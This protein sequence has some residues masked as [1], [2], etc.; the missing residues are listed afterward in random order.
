MAWSIENPAHVDT[1]FT[2]FRLRQT[3]VPFPDADAIKMSELLFF[4]PTASADQ[5]RI[6]ATLLADVIDR[7]FTK[8]GTTLEPNTSRNQAL[9]KMIDV[10]VNKDKTIEELADENDK[11]YLFLNELKN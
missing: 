7:Q 2:L 9:S 11:N 8:F 1:W 5:L 6:D 10:L 3:Q 4:N